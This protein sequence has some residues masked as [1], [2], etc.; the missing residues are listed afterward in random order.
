MRRV[1]LVLAVLIGGLAALPSAQAGPRTGKAARTVALVR[2]ADCARGPQAADRHAIF[3]GAMRR[4]AHTGRMSMRFALQERV[5]AGRFRTVRAPGLGRWRKSRPG[6]RRFSHRQRVLELAEGSAY[7]VVVSFRWHDGDGQVI[8]R[9]RRRSRSC[10]QP[11]PLSNLRLLRIGGG[12]P[13][14]GAPLF[15]MYNVRVANR[16]QVATPRFG[17]SLAVDG[18][19][20]D[21]QSVG[22][23][24][25]GEVRQLS[26]AGPACA[27]SLTARADPEDAV[28]ETSE[29]DNVLTVPCPPRR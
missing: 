9:A 22:A 6:V 28:R 12:L 20:V 27:R 3:R 1:A 5:G 23:L 18:G 4:V 15:S 8:R 29:R 17:V 10:S 14:A 26:F 7:R 2:V 24:S 19:I 13:L 16:G 11:G 21:R 25:P